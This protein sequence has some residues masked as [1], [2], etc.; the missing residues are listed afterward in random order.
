MRRSREDH[1]SLQIAASV[2][3]LSLGKSSLV[4]LLSD[5]VLPRAAVVVLLGL[6]VCA[7]GE[8]VVLL[9][10]RVGASCGSSVLLGPPEGEVFLI[11][12]SGLEGDDELV[13]MRLLLVDRLHALQ[14]LKVLLTIELEA[15]GVISGE[16]TY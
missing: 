8:S 1:L 5:V 16:S 11:P 4:L 15:H 3:R 7:H 13:D 14:S 6:L 10:P 12:D 9:G 2:L